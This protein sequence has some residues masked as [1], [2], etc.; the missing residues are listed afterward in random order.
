ML[1]ISIADLG[2]DK[3]VVNCSTGLDGSYQ[4]PAETTGAVQTH[5]F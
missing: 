4:Y 1:L 3:T 2:F 5:V